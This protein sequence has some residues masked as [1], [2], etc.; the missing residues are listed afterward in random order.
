MIT[1]EPDVKL[2]Y[3]DVL[4]VPRNSDISS[5]SHVDLR[6]MIAGTDRRKYVPIIAAN[7]DHVGTFKMAKALSHTNVMT[8]LV[9]HYSNQEI[10][11]FLR[12]YPDVAPYVFI[13]TGINA[14]DIKKLEELLDEIEAEELSHPFGICIDAAN[15]YSEKFLDAAKYLSAAYRGAWVIMAGNVV[16]PDRARYLNKYVDLVKI[17][18]GPGSACSTR[19]ETGI[20]YPQ[21]S[22]VLECARVA[23]VVADGG[24]NCPGD[25][26]KALAIGAKA[27][28][29]GGQFAGHDEGYTDEE[30]YKTSYIGGPV[31]AVVKTAKKELPF[32]G[33]ASKKAQDIHQGGLADYRASEGKEFLIKYRG[34]IENTIKQYLGGI[35]SAMT[36]QDAAN[37]EDLREDPHFVR[38]NRVLNNVYDRYEV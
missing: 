18:I 15:G 33:M 29:I 26:V 8:C 14:D 1:I 9:K 32:Y 2:D 13:S 17:G 30:L 16:T 38:V 19:R 36:Y 6:V 21:F 25:V 5:R 7:M 28:M 24:I 4:L 20:G 3:S 10:L 12:K 35:R 22:A 34:P 23:N 27:V 37:I 11:D 31:D